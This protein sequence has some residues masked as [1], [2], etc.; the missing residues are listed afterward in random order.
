LA[1]EALAYIGSRF[2]HEGKWERL[3]AGNE[4]EE[5][6]GFDFQLFLGRQ[7]GLRPWAEKTFG[8]LSLD[9]L[10]T[11]LLAIRGRGPLG[12]IVAG[13]IDL[14]NIDNVSRVAYHMG[15]P[16]NRAL[17][18]ELAEAMSDARDGRVVFA[19][20]AHDL[21]L[22]WLDLRRQLY[23]RL[24]QARADFAGKTM[25][26]FSMVTA[27][28]RAVLQPSDWNLVDSDLFSRL[29]SS[30]D[31]EIAEPVRRWLLGDLW[32]V[33]QLMWLRGEAP[34]YE[35]MRRFSEDLSQRIKRK[36]FAYRI[37]DKRTRHL[38]VLFRSGKQINLGETSGLWLL[39]VCSPLHRVFGSS[40][41]RDLLQLATSRFG[42]TLVHE[43][44]IDGAT[45][46]TPTLF[47]T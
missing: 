17:P 26:L 38:S 22:S 43:S 27:F 9:V 36:C 6:G 4:Q 42:S 41:H 29:S 2:D 37:S 3:F 28:E 40:E 34:S 47:A 7:S 15:L 24:M 18:L 5:I 30:S 19:D 32:S 13:D 21:I 20:T 11:I 8:S 10:K 12:G 33:S 16:C 25:L 46:A 14:D 23:S 35:E 1:E 45:D 39:G 31:D 44:T